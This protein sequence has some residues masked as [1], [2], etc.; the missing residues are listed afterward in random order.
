MASIINFGS[1]LFRT[2]AASRDAATDMTRLESIRTAVRAAIVSAE[3]ERDGLNQRLEGY[4][5]RTA[6]LLD[7]AAEYGERRPAEETAIREAERQLV[8]ALGRVNQ[9]TAHVADLEA[10]LATLEGRQLAE[11]QTA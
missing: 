4:Q 8:A 9:L 6:S 10:L 5:M 11:P 2:R 7:S 3:R 1:R